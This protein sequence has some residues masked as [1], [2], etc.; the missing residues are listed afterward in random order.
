MSQNLIKSGAKGEPVTAL[1][2]KLQQLG[3][4]VQPDGIFGP[5]TKAAVE[6]L[7]TLFGYDVDGVVGEGTLKL[8]DQQVGLHFSVQDP[9]SLKRA[10][11]AGATRAQK[12]ILQRNVE[13]ADVRVLQRKL[14]LL[15]FAVAVDGKF[16]EATDKAIRALQT[17]FGYDVDGSAGPATEK[18]I[19]QQIALGWNSSHKT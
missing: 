5:S 16:G 6:E 7:Q 8:V 9:A 15:G 4:E 10:V 12:R 19:H 17:A 1:Q 13:G 18:L 2:T 14:G 11:E 3:F